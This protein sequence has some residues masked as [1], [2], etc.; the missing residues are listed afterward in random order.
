MMKNRNKSAGIIYTVKNNITGE[1]YVGATAD[2]IENRKKDHELKAN[3]GHGHRFQEAI[4]TYGTEAFS[5]EEIDT[6]ESI[7]ELAQKE[8]QYVLKY[9][10]KKEGYNS[11]SGGGIKKSVYQYN[12]EDGSLINK[13]DCL[14]DAANTI[15][16][17]KQ[18]ISR[19]CLSVNKSFGGY[20]WSYDFRAPFKPEEDCRKKEVFQIDL[21]GNFIDVYSSVAEA[22]Y[23]TGVNTASIAKVCR[24]ERKTAGGY[25]WQY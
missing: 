21:E 12:I 14:E 9:N 20:L 24:G 23:K 17:I 10:S 3:S 15:G 8:K 13:F 19:A 5:W 25:I 18:Q 2:S 1:F 7:D 22:S 16:A 4:S 6:A 11:D